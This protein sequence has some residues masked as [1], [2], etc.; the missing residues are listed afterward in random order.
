M[1]IISIHNEQF[2]KLEKFIKVDVIDTGVGIKE[3]DKHKLFH[4]FGFIEETEVVNTHGIGMDLTILEKIVHVLEGK[5]MFN[6]TFGVGSKF[7][8]TMKLQSDDVLN[9]PCAHQNII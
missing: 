8:F 2:N 3:E 7:T 9:E 4:L 6:S 5:I 1:E